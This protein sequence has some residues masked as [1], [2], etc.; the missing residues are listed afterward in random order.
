[1]RFRDVYLDPCVPGYP[2][3]SS[4]MWSTNITRVAS[5][6]EQANQRWAEPIMSYSLPDAV[7][8]MDI[9]NALWNHWMVMKGAAHTF[10]WR[11]P[12]DFASV[13]LDAPNTIPDISMLDQVIGIGDGVTTSFQ[14]IKTYTAGVYSYVRSISK[15]IVSSVVVAVDGV[16]NPSFTVNRNN[17][18]LTFISPPAIDDVITAGY[19]FDV[20]VRFAADDVMSGIVRSLGVGGFGSIDLIEVRGC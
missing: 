20:E 4:P 14:L 2:A 5:G 19:L 12:M 11:D 1:M 17:G 16:S 6:A 3:I 7:R 9:F 8:S 15:P 18:V 10:P 13:P